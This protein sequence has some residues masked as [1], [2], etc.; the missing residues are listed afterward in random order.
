[1][2]EYFSSKYAGNIEE[3][4]RLNY[5]QWANSC[6][7]TLSPPGCLR[8]V[9]GEEICPPAGGNGRTADA[10][11][12]WLEKDGEA[13]CALL[14]SCTQP[15][16]IH[17][18]NLRSSSDMWKALAGVPSSA[19]TET[20]RSLLYR[21]FT[22]IKAIPGNPLSDFFGKLQE[23]VGLLAGTDHAIP[24]PQHR[25]QLRNLPDEYNVIRTI[26]EDKS[27]PGI[28]EII[29]TLMRTEEEINDKNKA[30]SANSASTSETA[31]HASSGS[32]GTTASGTAISYTHG[33]PYTRG[34]PFSRG[35][36]RGDINYRTT[37]YA[38]KCYNCGGE[39]H[40]AK[41]C[42]LS[43]APTNSEF[44]ILCFNCGD[45]GHV[46][47]KCP[48]ELTTQEQNRKGRAAYH[49]WANERSARTQAGANIAIDRESEPAL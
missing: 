32:N 34:R 47:G 2:T 40:R 48:H 13:Q 46:T 43:N 31:L 42:P 23:T 49:R 44:T 5:L 15:M 29:E 10:Y 35:R 41:D 12:T 9:L 11:Q 18:E 6:G 24:L 16:A 25:T 28:S 19:E 1:M 17:I 21:R 30:M 22:N 38:F 7:P 20:G 33:R 14:G 39:G 3:L 8:I 26:I 4:G 27:P 45:I 36:G 37:P